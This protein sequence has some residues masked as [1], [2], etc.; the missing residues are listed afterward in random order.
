MDVGPL[1]NQTLLTVLDNEESI[2]IEKKI[3][4]ITSRCEYFHDL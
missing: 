4:D 1:I 3:L 2:D